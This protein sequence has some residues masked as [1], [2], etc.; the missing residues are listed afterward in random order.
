[1]TVREEIESVAAE[2]DWD[3]A[4]PLQMY[5]AYI[6]DDLILVVELSDPAA[7]QWVRLSCGTRRWE[8][9][10]PDAVLESAL[11][12]LRDPYATVYGGEVPCPPTRALGTSEDPLMARLRQVFERFI[13]LEIDLI[14]YARELRAM[15]GTGLIGSGPV[16]DRIEAFVKEATR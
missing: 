16:A 5:A 3:L 8:V 11:A 13:Q 12:W 6:R 1:M 10:T 2:C 7:P 15:S 9:N 4:V 14:A